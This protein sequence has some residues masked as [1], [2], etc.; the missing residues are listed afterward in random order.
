VIGLA[1]AS[2]LCSG[3]ALAAEP[4]PPGSLPPCPTADE[5]PDAPAL[6]RRTEAVLEGRSSVSVIATKITAPAWSRT[7]KIKV[8]SKVTSS[9]ETVQLLGGR[10]VH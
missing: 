8:W 1:V 7:L 6:P 2:P 9:H 5:R 10:H 3:V 4:R